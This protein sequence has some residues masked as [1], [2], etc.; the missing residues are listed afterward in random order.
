MKLAVAGKG[1]SGKTSMSGTMARL[2]ARRGLRV[3]AIDGDSNP[4]LALTL[5]VPA[6]QWGSVPTLPR[7]LARRGE[8]GIELSKS[9]DEVRASHSLTGP[10]GTT[11]LVM[12]HP[13][14][15]EAGQ[16]CLCGMHATVRTLIAELPDT[17]EDITILDTEA[18]PEHLRRGTAK[19]ADVLVAVVEPY[20]KSLETGRRMAALAV[21]LGLDRVVL[22]ANKIRDD[23]E[24]EAVREFAEAH[25]L[26]VIGAVPFDE[27]MQAAERAGKSPLDHDEDM[28]FVTAIDEI[29]SRLVPVAA[30]G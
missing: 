2:L 10:D 5:G 11:L 28:P 17:D 15:E 9:V 4:N 12:A 7:D 30:A 27:G 26:E 1:G 19:Y 23:S 13:D 18:S 14:P 16:G 8:N 22:V 6:E 20:Y 29:A 21:E 3:L 25:D 24:L